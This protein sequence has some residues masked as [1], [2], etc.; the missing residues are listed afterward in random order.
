[1]IS[2]C[3]DASDAQE[4]SVQCN[5]YNSH[6]LPDIYGPCLGVLNNSNDL[7]E[8]LKRMLWSFAIPDL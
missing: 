7:E 2:S 1:M 6:F 4:S 8:I 5:L 3:Y